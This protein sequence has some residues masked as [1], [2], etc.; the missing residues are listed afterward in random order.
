MGVPVRAGQAA[1]TRP[2]EKS[3]VTRASAGEG[4]GQGIQDSAQGI[5]T[6]GMSDSGE[7]G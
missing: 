5:H 6:G 1:C 3:P 7:G 2:P 4:Q